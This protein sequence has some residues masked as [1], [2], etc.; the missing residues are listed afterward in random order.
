MAYA[1]IS[2][3]FRV[4][5]PSPYQQ[6]EKERRGGEEAVEGKRGKRLHPYSTVRKKSEPQTNYWQMIMGVSDM[7]MPQ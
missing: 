3:I 1:F 4:W 6:L 2:E 7:C 5:I